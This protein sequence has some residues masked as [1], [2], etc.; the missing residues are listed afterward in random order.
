MAKRIILG[1]S[2]TDRVKNVLDVQKVL[3]EFGCNIKTRLGL[4][5][6]GDSFCAASGLILLEACGDAGKIADMESMLR[7]VAGID[8]QKMVF[9]V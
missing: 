7:A 6:V 2:I 8:V 1:V 9:E 3:T 4:H 5:E